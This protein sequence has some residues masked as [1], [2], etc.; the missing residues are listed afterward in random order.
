MVNTKN[1]ST[2]DMIDKLQLLK[3]E[4]KL[5]L[6]KY[7]RYY[8]DEMNIRRRS[9]NFHFEDDLFSKKVRNIGKIYHEVLLLMKFLQTK[10]QVK[11]MNFIYFDLHNTVIEIRN[12]I[13]FVDSENNENDFIK[14]NGIVP[15]QNIP[16][17]RDKIVLR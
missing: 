2:E 13:E 3:G 4:T 15:N 7:I 6:L 10:P 12:D 11:N 17:S 8:Y 1:N 5:N 16:R 14:L 9:G